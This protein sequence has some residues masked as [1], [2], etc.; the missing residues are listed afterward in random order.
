[1]ISYL[2]TIWILKLRKYKP[3]TNAFIS[4]LNYLCQLLDSGKI[5]FPHFYMS[6]KSS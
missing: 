2:K 6:R 3:I 4:Q 5:V 1:M